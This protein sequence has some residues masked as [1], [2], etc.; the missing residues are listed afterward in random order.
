MYLEPSYAGSETLGMG[1]RKHMGY[2]AAIESIEILCH[3]RAAC[4]FYQVFFSY[5]LAQ[6]YILKKK[7]YGTV[8]R[9]ARRECIIMFYE[10]VEGGKH[11]DCWTHQRRQKI[12]LQNKVVPVIRMTVLKGERVR[13]DAGGQLL[14]KE[15]YVFRTSNKKTGEKR[16][17]VCGREAAKDFLQLLGHPNLPLFDPLEEFE[18]GYNPDAVNDSK[19]HTK[20]ST[21]PGTEE[22][23]E[24]IDPAAIQLYNA[25]N[26]LVI[27]WRIT[28]FNGAIGDLLNKTR[29]HQKYAD[30]WLK[31]LN[32]I[33]ANDYNHR[34]LSAMIDELCRGRIVRMEARDFSILVSRL[35][36]MGIESNL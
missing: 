7:L 32:T 14:S 18:D 28:N 23:E 19:D 12:I 36:D 5:G 24:D 17:I 2:G 33:L 25:V 16:T 30:S 20:S 11:M 8:S 6:K 31:S 4:A 1:R 22:K 13:S 35:R 15:Y 27:A 26:W 9:I 34:T 29:N 10:M 3:G 21:E